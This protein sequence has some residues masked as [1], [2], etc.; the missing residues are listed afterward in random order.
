MCIVYEYQ[1]VTNRCGRITPKKELFQ[2]VN[3]TEKNTEL[4]SLKQN[5]AYT[6]AN[7]TRKKVGNYYILADTD[8]NYLV[9]RLR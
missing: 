1:N 5:R 8:G 3:M 7:A 9:L 6:E 4:F 2:V